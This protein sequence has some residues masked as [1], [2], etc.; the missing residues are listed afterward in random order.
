MTDHPDRSFVPT[1]WHWLAY[2]VDDSIAAIRLAVDDPDPPRPGRV[3]PIT[4]DDS[5]GNY[6]PN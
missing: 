4:R 1:V 6:T 5:M 3:V 2:D